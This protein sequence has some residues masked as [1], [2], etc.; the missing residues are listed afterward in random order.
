MSAN[1]T[2]HPVYGNV[3]LKTHRKVLA[4]LKREKITMNAYVTNLIVADV[5]RR[6]EERKAARAVKR[7]TP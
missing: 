3:P 1:G 4:I 2:R 5:E 6:E 7:S